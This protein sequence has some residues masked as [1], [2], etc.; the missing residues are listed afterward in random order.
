MKKSFVNKASTVLLFLLTPLLLFLPVDAEMMAQSVSQPV[1]QFSV[2]AGSNSYVNTPVTAQL[3]GVRLQSHRGDLKLF[4]ITDG[5][6]H[7]VASQFKSGNPGYLTWILDGETNPGEIRNFEL[8]VVE[9]GHP[10]RPTAHA[11]RVKVKNDGVSLH[12]S[13]AGKPVLTYRFVE[14][15]VPEGVDEIYKRGGYIHPIWS[16]DGEVLSR[17]QPPDHY[18]HYGI[19]NP[20][21][22]TEFEGREVDFWNLAKRQG[23]VRA[24]HVLEQTDGAVFGGFK[25]LHKHIDFTSPNEE[26]TALREQ[27]EVN[28]WNV[29]PVQNVWLIDFVSTLNPATENPLT[30]KAYR[31]QG[32]S[33]RATEKWNDDNTDLLTSE[34]Y[35]KSNANATRARWID[36]NGLSGSE[37]GTSGILFMTNPANHNFPEQLRI[38]PEGANQG[39]E[40]VYINFNP[41]QEQDWKLNAG[42]SYTL[43]Y[44][45]F[46]YDGKIDADEANRYWKSFAYPPKVQVHPVGSLEGS[47]V[48]VYTRNGEG[49]VHDNIPNS[50]RAI[51]NLG[52]EYGFDVVASENPAL[53]TEDNLRQY[54]ALIFSNTNNETFENDSQR[55]A[56]KTYIQNGGGFVGIHSATGSERDWPWFSKLIG[57]N[58]ERHAPRQDFSVNII[59]HAHPSTSFLKDNWEIIDDEC[60]YFKELNPAIRVLLSADISTV[61]DKGKADFPGNLFGDGFPLAWYQEFDGGRQWYTS[62]GHRPEHYEEPEFKKHILGGIQWVVSG[63]SR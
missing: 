27:W 17:I 35:D 26:K 11:H 54:D 28:V 51:E 53:F 52:E 57:G 3:E 55:Q 45:M 56:L 39:E 46:V 2:H 25:A 30:I 13:I 24:E 40:N 48:L 42:N 4:E 41:A 60:Y 10:G 58:F 37:D 32:F 21:T 22:H 5:N 16:P 61:S 36:V 12:V 31:Y 49:Y 20:W 44:R 9:S 47:K 1:A 33:L 8:R 34:G 59:D 18:H 50:I 14:L 23:T 19:W 7:P 43:R 29:D 6:E 15:D 38:W 63:G 62:L